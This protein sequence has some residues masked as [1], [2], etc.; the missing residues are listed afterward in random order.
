MKHRVV[1]EDGRLDEPLL[2]AGGP[3]DDGDV[4]ARDAVDTLYELLQVAEQRVGDQQC[5]GIWACAGART[6]GS[7]EGLAGPIE[8]AS[9][10]SAGGR[11]RE[12]VRSRGHGQDAD[13]AA[14]TRGIGPRLISPDPVEPTRS[15]EPVTERIPARSA[16][17]RTSGWRTP[18]TSAGG[19]AVQRVDRRGRGRLPRLECVLEPAHAR[20]HVDYGPVPCRSFD[21]SNPVVG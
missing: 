2:V 19:P 18:C 17:D 21:G 11:R 20:A 5:R 8:V 14:E 3:A 13:A 9:R 16:G 1:V 6:T 10:I 12:P 7:G 4:R 15:A